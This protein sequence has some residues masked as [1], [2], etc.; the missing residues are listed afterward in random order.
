MSNKNIEQTKWVD[1]RLDGWLVIRM[2]GWI[3]SFDGWMH[4]LGEGMDRV[5]G[6]IAKWMGNWVDGW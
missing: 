6:W 3:V 2:D 4:G 5:G 1:G